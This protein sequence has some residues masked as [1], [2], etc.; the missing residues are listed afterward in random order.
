[1]SDYLRKPAIG[2]KARD[3]VDERDR[4]RRWRRKNRQRC[5]CG[6]GIW[7]GIDD[8]KCSNCLPGFEKFRKAVS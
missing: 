3:E 5:V 2:T 7:A 8:G 4:R 6:S 1:M